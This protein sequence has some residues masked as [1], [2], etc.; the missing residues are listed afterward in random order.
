M[1]KYE[2]VIGLE[3]HVQVRTASK[4]F[5]SCA[6]TFGAEPNTKV[7]PVC[8]GYPGV[9]PVPNKEAIRKTVIAGLLTECEIARFSKFD[10]KS[11]FYPD[12]VKNYQ[13]SQFDLPFCINGKMNICTVFGLVLYFDEHKLALYAIGLK[14]LNFFHIYQFFQLIYELFSGIAVTGKRNSNS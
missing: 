9:L 2:A 10:R 6:N 3:V 12:L 13:I 4:M 8:M 11:Y 14:N 5:C 1:A 7:C